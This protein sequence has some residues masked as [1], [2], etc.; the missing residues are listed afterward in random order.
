MPI[1]NMVIEERDENDEEERKTGQAMQSTGNRF[2]SQQP[3][4]LQSQQVG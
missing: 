3:P 2:N 4:Q 1:E